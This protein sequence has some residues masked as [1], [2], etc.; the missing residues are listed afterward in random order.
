FVGF[1]DDFEKIGR[2]FDS[3]V[4]QYDEAKRK[5]RDG[6]GN[7]FRKI[8]LLRELGAA[9]NKRIKPELLE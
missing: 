6:P 3:G 8:E 5:L 9:P 7:V 1:H 4:Q 2:I